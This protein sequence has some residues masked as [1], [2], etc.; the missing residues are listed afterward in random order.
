MLME[1][2]KETMPRF[3]RNEGMSLYNTAVPLA[4]FFLY[5]LQQD[6]GRDQGRCRK[7]DRPAVR[8]S[9]PRTLAVATTPCRGG[10]VFS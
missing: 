1:I 7:S 2:P 3:K 10:G 8:L 4:L 5:H 9:R 6:E